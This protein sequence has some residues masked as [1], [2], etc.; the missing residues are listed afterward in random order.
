MYHLSL[1]ISKQF[2]EK[3]MYGSP[4]MNTKI[5]TEINNEIIILIISFDSDGH[6]NIFTD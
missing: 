3:A 2:M 5:N 4:E 6:N 1:S